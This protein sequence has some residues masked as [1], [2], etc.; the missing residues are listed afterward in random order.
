MRMNINIENP[1]LVVGTGRSGTTAVAKVLSGD[2]SLLYVDEPNFIDALYFPFAMGRLDPQELIMQI[3]DEGWRGPMKICRSLSE[4]YPS[5]FGDSGAAAIRPYIKS[6]FSCVVKQAQSRSM[7]ERPE[8]IRE[9]INRIM[10]W[11]CNASGTVCWLIKQ[12]RLAL[13]L[14]QLVEYWP[15]LRIVHVARRLEQVLR[16]R[17]TRGYQSTFSGALTICMDRLE[18]VARLSRNDNSISMMH[19]RIEDIA[20]APREWF[21]QICRFVQ[22]DSTPCVLSCANQ[23]S[24]E[25]LYA[26][27]PIDSF[28]SEKDRAVI[29]ASREK[30]NGLFGSQLV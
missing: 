7:A 15:D 19:V 29:A 24:E 21:E 16:S 14:D 4:M 10:E 28:F 13:C 8:I 17:L 1:I 30:I 9:S 3:G 11:T 23:I 26:L 20:A 18:S 2:P 5:V 22:L 12:P 27:G 6:E 25:A